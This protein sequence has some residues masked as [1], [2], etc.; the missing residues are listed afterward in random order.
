MLCSV[1]ALSPPPS[2]CCASPVVLE[3]F[4]VVRPLQFA[5]CVLLCKS[6]PPGVFVLAVLLAF[7]RL[8]CV[9]RSPPLASSVYRVFP[10]WK[11]YIGKR[12]MCRKGLAKIV[13]ARIC[14][15]LVNLIGGV[16]LMRYYY[17]S[18]KEVNFKLRRYPSA[19]CIAPNQRRRRRPALRAL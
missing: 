19:S 9:W 4:L 14:V 11:V 12:L 18:G 7:L 1:N 15:Y 3:F 5:Q 8:P 10:I 6:R 13:L 17:A 2:C 16:F